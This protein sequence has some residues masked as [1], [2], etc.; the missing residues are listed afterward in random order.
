MSEHYDKEFFRKNVFMLDQFIFRKAFILS[1]TILSLFVLVFFWKISIP[2]TSLFC[3]V[4]LFSFTIPSWKR[5][6]IKKKYKKI[7]NHSTMIWSSLPCF[8]VF[9]R[10]YTRLM[11]TFKLLIFVSQIVLHQRVLNTTCLLSF[12]CICILNNNT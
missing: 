12:K 2:F 10:S 1:A 5:S 9:F 11:I 7:S 8:I 4:H 3:K 6:Y